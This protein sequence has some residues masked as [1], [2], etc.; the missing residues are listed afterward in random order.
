VSRIA[1]VIQL[2]LGNT[3]QIPAIVG[4]AQ[5]S[6]APLPATAKYPYVTVNEPFTKEIESLQ[7]RSGLA[8]ALI[9]VN[10]YSKDYEEAWE[11]REAI[12]VMLCTFKG[13]SSAITIMDVRHKLDTELFNDATEVH[14]LISRFILWCETNV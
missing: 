12:K 3:G 13:V 2:V 7:G 6:P 14:Q 1:A 8:G 9:Q 11:T 10:C 4:P 5:A